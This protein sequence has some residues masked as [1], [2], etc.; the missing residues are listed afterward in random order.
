M[1]ENLQIAQQY[2]WNLATTLM[3]C[4][5]LFENE[6]GYGVMLSAEYDGEPDT[7]IREYDPFAI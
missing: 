2:A 6:N 1:S 4:T 7:V 5:T 3:A